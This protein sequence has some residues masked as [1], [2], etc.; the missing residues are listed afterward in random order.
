MFMETPIDA[1]GKTPPT[2]ID[3][4]IDNQKIVRKVVVA[5]LDEN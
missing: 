5:S 1:V 3:G 4:C 2:L